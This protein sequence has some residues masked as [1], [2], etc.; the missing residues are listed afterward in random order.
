MLTNGNINSN[1]NCHHISKLG[2]NQRVVNSARGDSSGLQKPIIYNINN[3]EDYITNIF[4]ISS[5]MYHA[6]EDY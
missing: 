4:V 1:K 2:R 6:V 5:R 3:K